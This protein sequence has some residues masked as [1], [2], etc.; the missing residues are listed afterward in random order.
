LT[1]DKEIIDIGN[2]EK[3]DLKFTKI[4]LFK[5]IYS[6]RI[7]PPFTFERHVKISENAYVTIKKKEIRTTIAIHLFE[8]ITLI[9]K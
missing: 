6:L 5:S 3:Q 7:S 4:S 9:G 1:I 2:I 8:T